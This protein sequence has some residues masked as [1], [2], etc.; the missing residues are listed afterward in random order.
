MNHPSRFPN[1]QKHSR[2]QG[3]VREMCW[4]TSKNGKREGWN[5]PRQELETND[6]NKNKS[7]KT[8]KKNTKMYVLFLNSLHLKTS[9]QSSCVK[10]QQHLG[11]VS[12]DKSSFRWYIPQ[13]IDWA[14]RIYKITDEI[15]DNGTLDR[16]KHRIYFSW[17]IFKNYLFINQPSPHLRASLYSDL[18]K[19]RRPIHTV[20]RRIKGRLQHFYRIKSLCIC[21]FNLGK[22]FINCQLHSMTSWCR[23]SFTA[24]V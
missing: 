14:V 6:N 10:K 23:F 9:H 24:A 2:R 12:V 8:K 15:S 7:K 19:P 11:V 5:N 4:H 3:P 16:T 20:R 21:V 13:K 22:V 1:V 18:L 17:F